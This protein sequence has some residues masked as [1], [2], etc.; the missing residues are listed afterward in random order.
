MSK[1]SIITAVSALV[2][3]GATIGV[4]MYTSGLRIDKEGELKSTGMVAVKS[5][6]NGA[7]VYLNDELKTA[8]DGTIQG[9]NPGKYNLKVMRNGFT[10]WQKEIEVFE[11]LVTDITSVLVSKTPRLEPLTS[12]GARNPVISP[13][14]TKIAYFTKDGENPGV[15]VYPL[16]GNLQVNLF[17]NSPGVVLEDT[18]RTIYSNGEQLEWSPDERELLVS[19][20][21]A[22]SSIGG[23]LNLPT[24]N[25]TV[26]PAVSGAPT[27]TPTVAPVI[28]DTK[29]YFIVR[30]DKQTAESTSSAE[31]TRAGW[32]VEVAQKRELFLSK[33]QLEDNVT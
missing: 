32:Q 23:R 30:L 31:L 6:P 21:D 29:K 15:W 4:Y 24:N 17:K 5:V 9:L 26:T 28:P 16:G 27:P 14:L 20:S 2:L 33:L 22:K 11:Q 3:I 13:S 8:T 10:I 19:I 25:P 1:T 7:N 12:T 18:A